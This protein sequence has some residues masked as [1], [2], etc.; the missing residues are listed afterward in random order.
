MKV[1]IGAPTRDMI[2]GATA[3]SIMMLRDELVERNYDIVVD[4]PISNNIPYIR[5]LMA[6]RSVEMDCDALIFIDSDVSFNAKDILK[7]IESDHDFCALP[8]R[9]KRSNEHY[10]CT[11]ESDENMHPIVDKDGWLKLES[12]ATG[13]TK[14]SRNCLL[15]MMEAYKDNDYYYSAAD[16]IKPMH[17]ISLFEYTIQNKQLWGEDYTFCKRW[18]DIGGE[19]WLWPD[20]TTQHWGISAYSGNLSHFLTIEALKEHAQGKQYTKE[21]G[22][23]FKNEIDGWTSELELNWLYYLASR[24]DSFVEIGSWK[25]RSTHAICS[26]CKGNVY[27]IDHFKGTPGEHIVNQDEAYELFKKNTAGFDNLT[28]LRMTSSEAVNKI[29]SSDVVFI[30]DNPSYESVK[31]DIQLWA[32]KTKKI[33][34]GHDYSD[35]WPGVKKAVHEYFGSRVTVFETIWMCIISN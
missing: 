16:N 19:I 22:Y 3:M 20:A 7:L 32:P 24:V 5:N 9:L 2:F 25:G 33:I 26:G 10:L 14:Y 23:H 30:N 15:K 27:A 31:R 4:L 17:L 28:V 29:E 13:L 35:A 34:C 21:F 8:Y 12:V 6:M 1:Y 18:R 11:I